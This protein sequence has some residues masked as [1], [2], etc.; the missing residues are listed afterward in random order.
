MTALDLEF[1]KALH[2]PDEGYEIDNDY[3]LPAQVMRPV[4][5]YSV[6]T[7][8]APFNPAVQSLPLCP[9]D[10]G[11]SSPSIKGSVDA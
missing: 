10:L 4:F 6:S 1:E 7:T 2:Y 3:G 11:I 9:D 5:I 8:E